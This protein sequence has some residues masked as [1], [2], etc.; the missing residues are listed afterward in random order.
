MGFFSVARAFG[1]LH[2][3]S[4]EELAEDHEALRLRY[5]SGEDQYDELHRYNDEMVRRANEAYNRE[6][7]GPPESRN[8]EHGWYLPNDD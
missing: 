3:L 1:S 5:V 2:P 8:R 7:P 6:H 4:D